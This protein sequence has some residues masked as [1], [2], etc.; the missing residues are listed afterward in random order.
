[1]LNRYLKKEGTERGFEIED[2]IMTI[3]EKEEVII[4]T[5]YERKGLN[6]L[7]FL[8][9]VFLI[10]LFGRIFQ[11]DFLQGAY[12]QDLS[13]GNRIR[14]I[15]IKAPRGKIMDKFGQILVRNVPSIDV[16]IIPNKLPEEQFEREKIAIMLVEILGM[17]K[18]NI[19][20]AIESQNRKSLEPVLLKEN[21]SEDQSLIISEKFKELKGI[22]LENTA[23][24]N[25]ENSTIFSSIIGYDG[26]I[27]REELEKN[28][29][30]LM[31]D[32]I[33]KTGIE[34]QYEKNLRGINGARQVEVNSEEKV[35]KELGIKNSI[36]GS[37]LILN[38]DEGLQK[39][40]YDSI[41]SNLEQTATRVAAAV[42]IDPQTGG[43][44]AM[45]SFPSFDN[46]L[47]AGGI[48]NEDY[49]NIIENKNLPLFNRVVG[50][51]YPPGST[52]KPA[53]AVGALSEKIISADTTVNCSGGINLGVWHFGDWKTHGG[54]IDVRKA[55]AE[56]CDVFFYSVGG[57][58]G[59]IT[60]L[61][62][63][64]MKK[65]FNLF[66]FGELT[67]IDFPGEADGLIPD[68][69]WK[70]N[71]IKERW[72]IGDSYH[73][74]IG[75]G[76]I[77]ATPMQLANYTAALANG[78]KLYSP[79]VVSRVKKSDGEE[80][81]I[82]PQ[83]IR[84]NFVA[85]DVMNVVREGMRQTVTSGTA[86][87]LKDLPIEVAGK[88]GTAEFGTEKGKSHSWF[89]SFAPYNNP[90]I[91]MVVLVEGGGEGNSKSVPITKDVY[92]WYFNQK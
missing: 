6:M 5:P 85:P 15:V 72:Y 42:A 76:F 11:L 81:I 56:S 55:I 45:V 32:Y 90:E 70:E 60:G 34:K 35:K 13:K 49:K 10:F 12:Y 48:S 87:S 30:Y 20:A 52:V 61:G 47:F 80:E 86:Q 63:D 3:T 77:S 28:P 36:A 43:V 23:I 92:N 57:G 31:T 74:S 38:I 8:A 39:K 84:Q 44:L 54:G 64:K 71:I 2:S 40:L 27:T 9:L 18:G 14:S 82:S 22:A 37:D 69:A 83:I 58:Y 75:Q 50:G 21:I 62:M 33:G 24:R 91:A 19:E 67:G 7:F 88:T 1:M 53:L 73:S 17:E 89:I 59:N 16:V 78:G 46:N 4:E 65:Y 29:G 66:G 51:E 79:R 25:Y 26:K 68:E 41:A